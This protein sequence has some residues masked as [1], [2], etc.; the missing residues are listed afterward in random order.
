MFPLGSS[1]AL[2]LGGGCETGL[3]DQRQPIPWACKLLRRQRAWWANSILGG[4]N[5]PTNGSRGRSDVT[6]GNGVWIRLRDYVC[7]REVVA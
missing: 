7:E 6:R 1:G 3:D 2:V 4:T 5:R